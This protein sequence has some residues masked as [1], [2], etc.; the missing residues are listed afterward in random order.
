MRCM[1]GYDP[2]KNM[3]IHTGWPKKLA[4]LF[5]TPKLYQIL[6]DFQSYITSESGVNL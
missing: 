4:P 1:R 2:N 6:T 3:S 5:C